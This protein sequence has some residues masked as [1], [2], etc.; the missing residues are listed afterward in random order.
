MQKETDRLR[1]IQFAQLFAEWDQMV[2][3]DPNEVL[4]AQHRL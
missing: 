4:R 3:V 2:V 1:S